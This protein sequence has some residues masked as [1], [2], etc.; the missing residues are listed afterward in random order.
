MQI[1]IRRIDQ[2]DLL[3]LQQIGKETF[4]ETFAPSSKPE[5][6]E[7]YLKEA[8]SEEQLKAELMN[9]HSA[10]YFA[11]LEGKVIGYLKINTGDA[12]HE[13]QDQNTMELQRIYVLAAYHGKEAGKKLMDTA[14]A[15]ALEQGVDFIWLGVWEEN[16]RAI[17][18]YEKN[19]FVVF[20]EH[21]FQ[22]G[23]ELEMDIM[24][25]LEL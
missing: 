15:C 20:G 5:N 17:R 23:E 3:A 10:F 7:K 16:P 9:P 1:S 24:M 12:Q 18:F 14:I 13:L 19:G 22:F 11:E 2:E 8:F 21:Q 6:M 25:K 4:V